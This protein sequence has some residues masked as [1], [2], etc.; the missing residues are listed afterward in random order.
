M[1]KEISVQY[2][3]KKDGKGERHGDTAERTLAAEAKKHITQPV[4]QAAAPLAFPSGTPT[5]PP[6]MGNGQA[7]R[8]STTPAPPN[9][10]FMNPPAMP[11]PGGP[12]PMAAAPPAQKVAPPGQPLPPPPSGLPPRPPPSQAG[13]GGPQGMLPA[14]FNTQQQPVGFP[15]AGPPPGMPPHMPPP[16]PPPVRNR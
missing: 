6:T 7:G 4:G 14:G 9:V 5:A 8:V 11:A 16:M 15:G 2:A 3:Y 12:F 10:P 13:Y 1:N